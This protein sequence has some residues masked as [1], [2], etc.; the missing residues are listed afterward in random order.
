MLPLCRS[1]PAKARWQPLESDHSLLTHPTSTEKTTTMNEITASETDVTTNRLSRRAL[2]RGGGLAA[3]AGVVLTACADSGDHSIA[4][5]GTG[6]ASEGLSDET[7]TDVVLLRT[8][9]SVEKMVQDALSSSTLAA[10]ANASLMKALAGAHEPARL[11]LRELVT[12]R[13]GEPVDEANAKLTSNWGARALDLVA[14]SDRAGDDGLLLAHALETLL[15]STY[16]GFVAHTSEPALRAAMMRLAVGASR[17]AATIAQQIAP[18]TKGFV[19]VVDDQGVAS[20]ASLPTAFGSLSS[21][22]VTLGA[23]NESGVRET[24]TMETPSLNSYIW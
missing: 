6:A 10:G 7:V 12:T 3:V 18:G 4:R 9:M 11:A 14:K 8:A 15:A 21:I 2:L 16:Q 5:L 24:V 23:P 20:V 22:Q 1:L 13:N 19:P 17:R